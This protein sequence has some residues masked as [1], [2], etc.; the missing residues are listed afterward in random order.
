MEEL[1]EGLPPQVLKYLEY[2]TTLKFDKSPNY[3][4]C[5]KFWKDLLVSKGHA[6]D[7]YFDWLNKQMGKQIQYKD[8]ADYKGKSEDPKKKQ[9]DK[10]MLL[11]KQPSHKDKINL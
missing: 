11:K 3:D 10:R 8:Y 4:Y 1:C 9:S 6:T 7:I 5:R 2:V